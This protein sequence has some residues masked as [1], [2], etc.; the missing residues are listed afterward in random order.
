[1][2][3]ELLQE[4][5]ESKRK[6]SSSGKYIAGILGSA[7]RK[8]SSSQPSDSNGRGGGEAMVTRT[9]SNTETKGLP[10]TSTTHNGG[11]SINTTSVTRT[12]D[13]TALHNK[14]KNGALVAPG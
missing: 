6:R 10:N 12:T 8:R 13:P 7:S 14:A 5:T 11:Q 2:A 1:V 3:T 4:P 9:T